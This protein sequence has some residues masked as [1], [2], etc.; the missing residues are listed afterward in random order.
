[1]Y[2]LQFEHLKIKIHITHTLLGLGQH[3]TVLGCSEMDKSDYSEVKELITTNSNCPTSNSLF[4]G[5][6]VVFYGSTKDDSVPKVQ[7]SQSQWY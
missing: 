4:D 5:D 6:S 1:V 2:V 7:P 3:N